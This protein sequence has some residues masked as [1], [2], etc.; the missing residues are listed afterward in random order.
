MDDSAPPPSI[1]KLDSRSIIIFYQVSDS[2]RVG[3]IRLLS[4]VMG[5]IAMRFQILSHAG[6][7]VQGAG[8]SLVTDPWIIGSTYWRSWWNYPPVSRK[9]VK[10]LKPDFIYLTHIHW[11]HFQ[12]P[13]LRKFSKSTPILV[14]RGHYDRIKRDLVDMGFTDVRELRHAQ[15]VEL[16]PGFK[17]TSYQFDPFLDS[18]IVVECDGVTLLNAN[19]AKFMGGP[20]AQ[21]LHRHPKIHF[22]L[23]SHSSANSRLSYDI[24]DDPK[25]EVDDIS[26]YIS[27]FADF[28]QAVGARYAIPFA[29]NHCYLHKDVFPLNHTIQTPR[30]VAEYFQAHGIER[31]EV[32]IM[33]SGD[34]WSSEQGFEIA[35]TT[36]DY[37]DQQAER[38][39][40]YR[41]EKAP[42]LEKFYAMEAKAR[43]SLAQVEKYFT[44]LFA[45]MPY[46]L[47]WVFKGHPIRFVLTAGEKTYY[48]EIDFYRRTVSELSEMVSTPETH[49][50]VH[51]SVFIMRQCMALN[52]FSH[53]SISKRVRYRV[54]KANKKYIN[55]M[56]LTFN[57]Y[58]YDMFPLRLNLRPRSLQNWLARWR[59][60][61]LIA[62]IV[63]VDL[64]IKRKFKQEKY[65]RGFIRSKPK[66]LEPQYQ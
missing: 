57:M 4:T 61:L 64:G 32:K 37:F 15:T 50:E 7:L 44:K 14:P 41:G 66:S 33:L 34:S 29:S 28:V 3:T 17:V 60:V 35:A 12:G 39:E 13:S 38:L 11:D 19:D 9:L 2:H 8:I 43:I 20:L 46:P 42:I 10:S 55:F 52:L 63:L 31:P 6:L 25:A 49:P 59:E 40:S 65:L 47:R 45:V 62:Q 5:G 56:N 23:R 58:E 27:N 36:M 48:Y 22:V 21:I 26:A 18:A 1:L 16:T 24:I 53:L 51:T 54:T 30:M